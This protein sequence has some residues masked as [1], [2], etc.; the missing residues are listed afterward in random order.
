MA[1]SSSTAL[2]VDGK[3]GGTR[4]LTVLGMAAAGGVASGAPRLQVAAAESAG[5]R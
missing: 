1:T 3:V 5:G 4:K 2:E